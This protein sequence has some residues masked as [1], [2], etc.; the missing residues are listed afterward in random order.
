MR[1]SVYTGKVAVITGGASGIG[2]AIA[3]ELARAGAEVVLAD[4]QVELA[5]RIAS[6][7]RSSGGG[8]RACEADVRSFASVARVVEETVAR[9]GTV[10]Y[11]FNN[12]GIGVGGEMDTYELRDWDDVIDVNLRGVAHGIQASGFH[13]A[14]DQDNAHDSRLADEL[15]AGVFLETRG[16]QSRLEAVELTARIPQTF[17]LDDGLRP[18]AQ[19][20][21]DGKSKQVDAARRYVFAHVAGSDRK[22]LGCQLVV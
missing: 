21:V 13:D 12:A 10:D 17:D 16:H 11:F 8:A 9:L 6:E 7:I 2:A 19:P 18:Q 20:R 4:R 15:A 5:E 3:K 1:G 14:T 22:A